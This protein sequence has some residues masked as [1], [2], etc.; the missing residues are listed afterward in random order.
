M[1]CDR[2]GTRLPVSVIFCPRCRAPQ[3]PG[4]VPFAP[5]TSWETCEISCTRIKRR[6]FRASDWAFWVAAVGPAGPYTVTTALFKADCQATYW[7]EG[8]VA[9]TGDALPVFTDLV[10]DLVEAG[11]ERLH[12]PGNHWYSVRFRRRVD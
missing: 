5:Q 10:Q 6:R 7:G 1:Y 8:P 3:R 12:R 11:W 4:G 9:D 2:C